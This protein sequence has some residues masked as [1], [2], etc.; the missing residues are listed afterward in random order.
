MAAMS[1]S[2]L[3]ATLR[4]RGLRLT[5]AR[6]RILH[7]VESLDHCTPEQIHERVRLDDPSTHLTTVYRNLD[8][9][10]EIGLIGHTHLGHG[11]PAYH[12]TED[13]HIHVVCHRCESVLSV[14]ADLLSG[15]VAKMEQDHGF[16]VDVGHVTLSGECASCRAS[17]SGT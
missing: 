5:T 9:L 12:L 8:V 14:D 13:K 16:R 15:V 2:P 4:Q 3:A 10:E 7:A 1:T 11:A 17:S 6:A